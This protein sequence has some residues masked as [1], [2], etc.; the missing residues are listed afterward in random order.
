MEEKYKIPSLTVDG[1]IIKEGKILLVKRGHA[2]YEGMW[3]TPGG[4]VEYGE[5]TEHAVVREVKEE[6]GLETTLEVLVGVYSDPKRDPRKHVISIA[7]LLKDPI[8]EPKGG[9]DAKEAKWWDLDAL[10]PL[11]FDHDRIISDAIKIYYKIKI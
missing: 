2:P 8:G 11:A 10:P 4:F 3:A 9:D 5:T 1:I 6:T 7:Y